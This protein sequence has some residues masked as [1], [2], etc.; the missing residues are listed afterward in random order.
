MRRRQGWDL[1]H[2]VPLLKSL[3]QNF[4]LQALEASKD[5]QRLL[6]QLEQ[7][8]A[9]LHQALE[10]SAQQGDQ[11]RRS[12]EELREIKHEKENLESLVAE[13]NSKCAQLQVQ[14][15]VQAHPAQ[16]SKQ[17]LQWHRVGLH[18]LLQG[19]RDEKSDDSKLS[20][21]SW[22]LPGIWRLLQVL[23][24]YTA[25]QMHFPHNDCRSR[26]EA[27]PHTQERLEDA[28]ASAGGP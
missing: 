5:D 1:V 19:V 3:I 27:P 16:M 17:A 10:G 7:L 20:A 28:I 8:R 13:L 11:A 15:P 2:E 6:A 4:A 21:S 24:F 23:S 26:T 14:G 25:Q 12:Q 9:E 22:H 18:R